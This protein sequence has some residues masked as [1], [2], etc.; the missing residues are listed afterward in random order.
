MNPRDRI[1]EPFTC[2]WSLLKYESVANQRKKDERKGTWT[3]V[4]QSTVPRPVADD[5]CAVCAAWE[6]YDEP[7][8][9]MW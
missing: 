3:C 9:H 8:R 5:E 2:R 6:P 7:A 4:G 1:H